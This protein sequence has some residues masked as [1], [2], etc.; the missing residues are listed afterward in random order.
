[1]AGEEEDNR[2][3]FPGHWPLLGGLSVDYYPGKK[4]HN[5]GLHG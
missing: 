2:F 1:V 5:H 3:F 4:K